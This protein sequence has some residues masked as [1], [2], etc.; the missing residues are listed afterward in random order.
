MSTNANANNEI[1]EIEK[2]SINLLVEINKIAAVK[3]WNVQDEVDALEKLVATCGRLSF[4]PTKDMFILYEPEKVFGRPTCRAMEVTLFLSNSQLKVRLHGKHDGFITTWPKIT[5]KV[6]GIGQ[7]LKLIEEHDGGRLNG[8]AYPRTV[9]LQKV[10]S[11]IPSPLPGP[12]EAELLE[13]LRLAAIELTEV[14]SELTEVK[15]ILSKVKTAANRIGRRL[16]K[17]NRLGP[18]TNEELS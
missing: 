15:S 13:K 14:K 16:K 7:A 11:K 6:G 2:N 5:E 8:T 10:Y 12:A 9:A 1:E 3:K 17:V 4:K 18:M